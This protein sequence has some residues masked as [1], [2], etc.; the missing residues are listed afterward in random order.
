MLGGAIVLLIPSCASLS[1]FH[2]LSSFRSI[3][4]RSFCFTDVIGG[5]IALPE[6]V[7]FDEVKAVGGLLF[8]LSMNRDKR[9]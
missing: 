2:S 6:T 4:I 5:I 7:A 9:N 1:F 3:F 8:L